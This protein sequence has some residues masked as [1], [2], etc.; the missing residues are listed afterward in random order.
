MRSTC[1]FCRLIVISPTVSDRL[2]AGVQGALTNIPGLDL[3]VELIT[4]RFTAG[5]KAMLLDW[6][7]GTALD[8]N[9]ATRARKTTKFGAAKY[10]YPPVIM[11]ELR[12][13]LERRIAHHLPEA[14]IL[15]WT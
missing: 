13:L 9:E 12:R 15:Y 3:T 11:T 5:S 7:P 6:Y 1:G 14:Q 8:M 10:V 4:H 2:L